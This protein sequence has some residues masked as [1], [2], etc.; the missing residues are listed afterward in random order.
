MTGALVIYSVKVRS[1]NRSLLA[2]TR[3]Q[4]DILKRQAV[5][6]GE[7][8]TDSLAGAVE[9]GKAAYRQAADRVAG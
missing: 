4:A 7:A 9:L 6:L 1:R 2:R 8:A 5:K 3:K